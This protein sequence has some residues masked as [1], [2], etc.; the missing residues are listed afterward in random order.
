MNTNLSTQTTPESLDQVRGR[1]RRW[2]G[3]GSEYEYFIHEEGA[4]WATFSLLLPLQTS[5]RS[6]SAEVFEQ[7]ALGLVGQL[8]DDIDASGVLDIGVD[9]RWLQPMLHDAQIYVRVC[10]TMRQRD[11]GARA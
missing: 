4:P 11:R 9:A 7:V 2:M 10:G 8:F 1:L 5:D 6:W 3:T